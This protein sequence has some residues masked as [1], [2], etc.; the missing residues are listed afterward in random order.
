MEEGPL[1]QREE[2]G[3]NLEG[4]MTLK[5]RLPA[6]A[7]VPSPSLKRGRHPLLI[8]MIFVC[9]FFLWRTLVLA[10]ARE[11][12]SNFGIGCMK[13]RPCPLRFPKWLMASWPVCLKAKPEC[14]IR[15][16]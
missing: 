5:C 2:T 4:V 15:N 14:E 1:G 16:A 7:P 11:V 13:N 12:S 6:P 10:R 9:T 8:S 3:S